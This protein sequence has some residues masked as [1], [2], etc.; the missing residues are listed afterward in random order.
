M[1]QKSSFKSSLSG[2]IAGT[3]TLI[4]FPLDK[5]RIH[6]IVSEKQ[7]RNYIPFYKSNLDLLKTMWKK[8]LR[9]TYRGFH[10]QA[11]TSIAWAVYFPIYEFFKKLPSEQFKKDH[12]ELYKISVASQ[13]AVVSNFITNPLF[14]VKTRALLLH[15]SETWLMDTWESVKKTWKVDGITGFWRGYAVGIFLSFD[16]MLTMY[17]YETFKERLPISS[18]VQRYSV[19]GGLSKLIAYTVFFPIVFLKI[20]IQQEQ[21]RETILV[22][23][24]NIKARGNQTIYEGVL[25]CIKDTWKNY[26]FFGF[27]R[28]LSLSLIRILPHS[29]LFFTVYETSYKFL[30]SRF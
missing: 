8:G 20:S 4:L 10:F 2:F 14:V 19:S 9:Y 23:S 1:Q 7:Q 11:S 15:N 6:M 24:K 30:E 18:D 17:L 13:A 16:G 21:F 22:N 25:H 29:S 27:Y 28:G 12:Y 26:G 3:S 5:M